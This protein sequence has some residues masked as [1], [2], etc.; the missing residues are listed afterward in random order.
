MDEPLVVLDGLWR[1][2]NNQTQAK[3]ELNRKSN[4]ISEAL[5]RLDTNVKKLAARLEEPIAN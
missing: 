1:V 3:S 4:A 5:R 2:I